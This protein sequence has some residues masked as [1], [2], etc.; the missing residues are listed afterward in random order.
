[1]MNLYSQTLMEEEV[2]E[3]GVFS[4]TRL[5]PLCHSS[6]CVSVTL[7]EAKLV[8]QGENLIDFEQYGDDVLWQ[9]NNK[10]DTIPLTITLL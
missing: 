2:F 8:I 6:P 9:Y 7:I 3:D 5:W 4:M 10:P 1:M